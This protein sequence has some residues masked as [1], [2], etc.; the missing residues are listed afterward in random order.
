MLYKISISFIGLLIIHGSTC[1]R[2]VD[3]YTQALN[4]S[5]YC[6][7][8]GEC[9]EGSHVMCLYNS[10][11]VM[12]PACLDF[13]TN[14]SITPDYANLILTI[15]NRIR[16][17][18]A[19]G[20][21]KTT[22]GEPFPKAYGMVRVL[23]DEE[24]ATF[25]Q[26]WANQCTMHKDM[27][28]SSKRFPYV[29]QALGMMR[30]TLDDWMPIHNRDFN[31]TVLTPAKVKYAL[32]Q[33]MKAW[34]KM[35]EEVDPNSIKMLNHSK[36]AVI[37]DNKFLNLIYGPLTHI[38]CG[39]SVYKEFAHKDNMAGLFFNCIQIVC[40][41]SSRPKFG[42]PIYTVDPPK[43]P[44]YTT[45]CGCPVGYDEDED[46]LCYE[47]GRKMPY[48]CKD[49]DQCKPPV[50]VLPI[51][52]VEDAPSPGI[53]KKSSILRASTM[54]NAIFDRFDTLNKRH[55]SRQKP[56]I[57]LRAG[58]FELPVKKRKQA[59]EFKKDV[60]PRKDFTNVKK[61]VS[62][63]LDTKRH[64]KPFDSDFHSDGYISHR[65]AIYSDYNNATKEKLDEN[66]NDVANINQ[67][68]TYINRF[69]ITKDE[70]KQKNINPPIGDDVKL[71][72]LLDKL[73]EEVKN[74][75][76]NT[77]EKGIFDQKIRKI[78]E[79]LVG[80]LDLADQKFKLLSKDS[81]NETITDNINFTNNLSEI[82]H[83]NVD[84]YGLN[85]NI[86]KHK[87]RDFENYNSVTNY[88]K[89]LEEMQGNK[90]F[91]SKAKQI[92][93]S[94]L[95]SLRDNVE[96]R[97]FRNLH[98]VKGNRN[99]HKSRHLKYNS[100]EFYPL[101]NERRRYYH[102]KLVSLQKKIKNMKRSGLPKEVHEDRHIRPVRPTKQENQRRRRPNDHVNS[103][104]MPDRARFLHGF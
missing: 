82:D 68:L 57:F 59:Q 73:E 99:N 24:L 95:K 84:K 89:K 53:G 46:C 58:R 39:I 104:Y 8:I 88:E 11:R 10:A 44:G 37:H 79:R 85:L 31:E 17:K 98:G 97:R 5:D 101:D 32:K 90:L 71:M 67:K 14:I 54:S 70:L 28:R 45:R 96:G 102:Q 60:A 2:I 27:C 64:G 20:Q 22:S 86:P 103:Y 50:V 13:L 91:K 61:L 21:V 15:T 77:N 87:Y 19:N 35:K 75:D 3:T 34:W 43:K 40:N 33:V 69:N 49:K 30:L 100:D 16:S 47:T 62:S 4:L 1:S 80:K 7:R 74:I 25:A 29:G 72:F 93:N 83:M 63:Y 48:S 55:L 12:G 76:L 18:I 81:I 66:K 36:A 38:G 51:F 42:E 23:W 52:T 56:S 41:F 78:Y 92:F 9:G 6:P 26:V 94:D 65:P